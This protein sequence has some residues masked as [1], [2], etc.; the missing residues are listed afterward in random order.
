MPKLS[1]QIKLLL[2]IYDQAYDQRAWHGTNLRGSLKGLKLSELL[3]RPQTKRHNI[4][5]ITLHC[6]YWK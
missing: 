1:E 3:H 2:E 4:W 5:E 6:A